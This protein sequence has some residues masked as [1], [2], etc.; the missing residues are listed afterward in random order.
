LFAQPAAEKR[1]AL[2]IGNNEY[3][4]V[5][6]LDNAVGDARAMAREFRALGF[7]VIEK[8]NVDQRAMKAAVREFVQR[9]SNGGVGAFFYAGHGVQEG[10]NNYLLPVDVGAP[11]DPSALA[12]EA[13][14]LNSDIMARVGQAGA[15]FSLIVIDACRDNPFPRNAGRSI[16]APRGLS[17]ANS[18]P[19]G[20]VV[21][22]SAGVGQQ[23]LDRLGEADRDPNG[24]FTREFIKE[25]RRPGLEVAELVRN[26]RKRVKDQAAAVKHEQTPAL[27]IQADRFYL[28]PNPTQVT[29]AAQADDQEAFWAQLDI[30][31]PCEYQAYLEQYP[32]GRYATIARQRL[33]VCHAPTGE[34]PPTAGQPP[35]VAPALMREA[36]AEP[37]AAL[38]KFALGQERLNCAVSCSWTWGSARRQLKAW[39]K[40]QVWSDLGAKVIEISHGN[41]LA[42]YYLGASAEGLGYMDA[43]ATYYRLA[44]T[45]PIKC[46]GIFNNCDGFKF[47]ADVEVALKRI[48]MAQ[49]AAR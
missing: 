46:D 6:K 45:A 20:M 8:L 13:V 4:N 15:K 36:G 35:L 28:V 26:V 17:L 16:G 5:S 38:R 12:D 11:A 47:P 40:A 29:I 14:E 32:Q 43:A 3:R 25:M 1:V 31:R 9:A 7:D 42:Y 27:Y 37:A 21:V 19:E 34:L 44:L 18:A 2:V 22:Y 49:P 30:A 24:L 41:D 33:K 23:A 48:S 10:G 39:H